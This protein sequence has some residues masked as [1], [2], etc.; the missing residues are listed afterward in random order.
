[1]VE[2]GVGCGGVV[3]RKE[4]VGEGLVMVKEGKCLDCGEG[5]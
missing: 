4:W 2:G 1:M 3:E 5:G